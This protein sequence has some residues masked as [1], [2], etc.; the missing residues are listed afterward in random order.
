MKRSSGACFGF[1]GKLVSFTNERQKVGNEVVNVSKITLRQVG[2]WLTT[3]AIPWLEHL[4]LQG[5]AAI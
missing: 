3:P 2:G 1:G 5:P 4:V